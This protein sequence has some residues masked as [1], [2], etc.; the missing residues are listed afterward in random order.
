MLRRT[1]NKLGAATAASGRDCDDHL[2]EPQSD[3][4]DPDTPEDERDDPVVTSVRRQRLTGLGI[5]A[6]APYSGILKYG[7]A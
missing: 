7:V 4:T 6:P 2:W 1:D 3:P 5:A